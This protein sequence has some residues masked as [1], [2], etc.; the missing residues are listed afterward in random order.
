M[1]AFYYLIHFLTLCHCFPLCADYFLGYSAAATQA[2][3]AYRDARQQA[4]A[5]IAPGA[6]RSLEE[7]L[8]GFKPACNRPTKCSV[9]FSAPGASAGRPL[10]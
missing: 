9:V 10:A 6:S 2:I 4:G 5:E 8:L 3:E 7:Q 1:P